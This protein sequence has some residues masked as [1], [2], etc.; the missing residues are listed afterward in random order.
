MPIEKPVTTLVHYSCSE[1]RLAV[2]ETPLKLKKLSSQEASVSTKRS[3]GRSTATHDKGRSTAPHDRDRLTATRET[4]PSARAPK[5]D[6]SGL[7]SFTFADGRQCRTP[8]LSCASHLC[9]FHAQKEA[10]ARLAAQTGEAISSFFTQDYLSACDL[11]S[12]LSR[13]FFGVARGQIKRKT[14]T[15]LA[16]LGQTLLQSIPLAQ[17]EYISA[18]GTTC[19]RQ[20]VASSFAGPSDDDAAASPQPT[21]PPDDPP[22]HK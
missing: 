21:P 3:V 12:A 8:R 22:D 5:K 4:D 2:R 9:S 18:F 14:A 13:V 1:L 15:T 7:C 6:R 19:W 11:T 10:Q 20:T 16:Y 17:H